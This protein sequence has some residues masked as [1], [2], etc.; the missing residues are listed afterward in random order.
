MPRIE[1]GYMLIDNMRCPNCGGPW[2]IEK[3]LSNSDGDGYLIVCLGSCGHDFTM[4]A[5][6]GLTRDNT[7]VFGPRSSRSTTKK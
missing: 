6:I 1:H 7:V 4:N 2:E 5:D 3:G